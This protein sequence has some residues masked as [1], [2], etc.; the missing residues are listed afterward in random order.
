MNRII[1]SGFAALSLSCAFSAGSQAAD[2]RIYKANKQMQQSRVVSLRNTRRPG[3][4]NLLLRQRAYRV[5]Q[6]GFARCFIYADKDC[7]A[8]D[9]LAVRWKREPQTT[10]EIKPGARWFVIADNKRG[11]KLGSWKCEPPPAEPQP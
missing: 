5:A 7:P 11:R 8:G 9:E 10:T 2:F 4:H 1:L 3:C 6:V